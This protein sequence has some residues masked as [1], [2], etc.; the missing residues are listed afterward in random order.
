MSFFF[1]MPSEL[2]TALATVLGFALLGDMD[3]DQQ[4]AVGN[5]LMLIGQILTTDATQAQTLQARLDADQQK[6]LEERVRRLEERLNNGASED[7]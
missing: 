6:A 7:A 4:N 1:D 2:M 3:A 5:F